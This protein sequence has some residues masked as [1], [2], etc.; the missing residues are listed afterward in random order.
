MVQARTRG[1]WLMAPTSV[2]LSQSATMA[3]APY[4]ATV[5]LLSTA[6]HCTTQV[7]LRDREKR[8]SLSR[9]GGKGRA[10]LGCQVLDDLV[11]VYRPVGL[12][13]ADE[14]LESRRWQLAPSAQLRR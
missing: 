14:P 11:E 12:S 10:D 3:P 6:S 9:V 5:V 7:R 4:T 2:V 1:T 8:S 13:A